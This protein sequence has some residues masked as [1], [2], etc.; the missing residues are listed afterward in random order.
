MIKSEKRNY[1]IDKRTNS[2]IH[3]IYSEKL[4][5]KNLNCDYAI[6]GEVSIKEQD[7]NGIVKKTLDEDIDIYVKPIG[8]YAEK[9]YKTL[10][11]IHCNNDEYVAVKEKIYTKIIVKFLIL[12]LLI[13]ALFLG[14]SLKNNKKQDIDPNAGD[15]SSVLKRPKNISNSKI[16]VPG[17]G[18]FVVRKGSD[19]INTVFFN[20]EDNPCFFKFTLIEKSTNEILYESKLVPPGKGIT[21][22]KINKVFNEFGSYNVILKLQ[23]FD[24]ENT[25]VEYNGADMEVNL[26]VV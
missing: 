19:T 6:I 13:L 5:E 11:Y 8:T 18:K 15:C 17:Y 14:F 1:F 24:L 2:K 23:S 3:Y 7:N 10:G 22:I 20:P 21:S 25:N 4:K 26:N 12:I 16:L 9:K